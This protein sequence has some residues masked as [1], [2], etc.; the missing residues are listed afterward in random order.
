MRRN[1]Y[2]H[3]GRKIN[4]RRRVKYGRNI[5]LRPGMILKLL[6]YETRYR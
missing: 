3:V 4:E 6:E 2:V 1:T 5:E